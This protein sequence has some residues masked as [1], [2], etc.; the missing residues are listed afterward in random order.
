MFL[1]DKP[2]LQ[3]SLFYSACNL[4]LYVVADWV[5]HISWVYHPTRQLN[6]RQVTIKQA[7]KYTLEYMAWLNLT[8]WTSLSTCLLPPEPPFPCNPVAAY[9]NVHPYRPPKLLHGLRLRMY[10][11]LS[12]KALDF[13]FHFLFPQALPANKSTHLNRWSHS[14]EMFVKVHIQKKKKKKYD[15]WLSC[16]QTFRLKH[17]EQVNVGTPFFYTY[18][19]LLVTYPVDNVT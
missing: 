8:K 3:Y 14:V 2:H 7:I 19:L 4:A 17:F 13:S 5:V 12:L 18:K 16:L 15:S 6:D 9:K 10:N 11:L 1:G